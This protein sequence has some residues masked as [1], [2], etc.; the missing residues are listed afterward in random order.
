MD[1]T[2]VAESLS[3]GHPASLFAAGSRSDLWAG[4]LSSSQGHGDQTGAVRAPLAVATCLCGTGDRNH[5]P[6]VLG[7][8]HRIQRTK[9]L[10][11]PS[12]FPGL[13]S[14]KPDPLGIA[15]GHAGVSV[16][17]VCRSRAC[18]FDSGGR[19]T[20][21]SLRAARRLV[22]SFQVFTFAPPA[23]GDS[24]K[25]GCVPTTVLIPNKPARRNVGSSTTYA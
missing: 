16:H 8:R 11:A 4:L 15:E 14:S 5:S 10:P 24:V 20:S 2:A 12:R 6:R 13:L 3:V 25:G 1:C 9:P 19:R 18:H 22:T 17:P 21:S 23:I 7:P